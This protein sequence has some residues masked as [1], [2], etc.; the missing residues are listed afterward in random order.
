[1]YFD[2]HVHYFPDFLAPK[3]M[4]NLIRTCSLQ[5]YSDGTY[6]GI[7]KNL[8]KWDCIG[9]VALHIA[10]N[11]HQQASV[12]SFALETQTESLLCFGSVHPD[13][14]D[15]LT[16]LRRIREKG[17][18]GIKF[19]PDYQDFYVN[20]KKMFPIYEEI[21]SLGLPVAFHTGRDPYSPEDIHCTPQRL[22]EV[23]DTFP[24]MRIIA[25]HMGG[26]YMPKE[27]AEFLS[28]KKNVWFDTAVISE[29]LTPASFEELTSIV[30]IDRVFYATDCPWSSMPLIT[31][32][33]EKTNFSSDEKKRIYYQNALEFFELETPAAGRLQ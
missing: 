9:A 16:E 22:A 28:G 18:R 24:G 31:D 25:A 11:P 12:N 33:I 6:Q 3:A 30:G 20:D 14:P 26:S 21:T 7:L 27:S 32:I 10:T 23:A 13:A 2:T 1:M 8:K 15:A 19:H 17:L 4:E 29:F 5:H